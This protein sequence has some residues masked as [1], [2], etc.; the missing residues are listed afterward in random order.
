MPKRTFRIEKASPVRH[1]VLP[2]SGDPRK[3]GFTVLA[4]FRGYKRRQIACSSMIYTEATRYSLAIA[5][6]R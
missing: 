5:I 6:P 2:G 4:R 1:R 3:P